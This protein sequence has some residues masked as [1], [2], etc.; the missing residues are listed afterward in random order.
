LVAIEKTRFVPERGR[1]RI[2]AMVEQRG[3]WCV[4]RQRAWGVPIAIFVVKKT[5]EAL[6]DEKVLKRIFEIFE[7]EGSDAWFNRPAQD[8]LGAN[9]K[10]DD[11]EQVRDII[12]VWF[13]SGST[14]G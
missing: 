10:A 7:K 12:D 3:D 1:N 6:K 11:F 5:G 4:S 8:F 13:E 14:Q 2:G 9:Y